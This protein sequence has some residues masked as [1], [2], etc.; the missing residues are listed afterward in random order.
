MS[1]SLGS[2]ANFGGAASALAGPTAGGALTS[3]PAGFAGKTLPSVT[4]AFTTT[5]L[6]ERTNKLFGSPL[7]DATVD[8]AGGPIDDL[9]GAG[10]SLMDALRLGEEAKILDSAAVRAELRGRAIGASAIQDAADA[11]ERN[12]AAAAS[13]GQ[14]AQSVRGA[15]GPIAREAERTRRIALSNALIVRAGIERQA[16]EA[17]RGRVVAGTAGGVQ[18]VSGVLKAAFSGG[19]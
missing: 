6:L 16:S 4:G 8:V 7:S 1:E 18:A 13:G 17:R 11:L 2:L 3:A 9:L 12:L 15:A 19:P 10:R 5:G 14:V